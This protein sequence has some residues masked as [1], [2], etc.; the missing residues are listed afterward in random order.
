MISG[1][2]YISSGT[3]RVQDAEVV[4]L[5]GRVGDGGDEGRVEGRV[6]GARLLGGVPALVGKQEE[7]RARRV[8]VLME[9]LVNTC[10]GLEN[11]R[12]TV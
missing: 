11:K 12:T 7:V 5:L 3:G 8:V 10:P 1:W 2:A 6:G 4:R 9:R